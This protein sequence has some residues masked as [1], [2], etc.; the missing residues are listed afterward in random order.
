MANVND[1]PKELQD[2]VKQWTD[3]VPFLIAAGV[4]LH[5]AAQK[6]DPKTLPGFLIHDARDTIERVVEKLKPQP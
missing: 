2:L 1:L 5:K 4:L 3:P 6:V